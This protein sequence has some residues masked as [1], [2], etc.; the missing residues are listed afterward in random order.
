[1]KKRRSI[2]RIGKANTVAE[3]TLVPMVA[4]AIGRSDIRA[5]SNQ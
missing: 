1:M 3:I 5:V 4:E 2:S